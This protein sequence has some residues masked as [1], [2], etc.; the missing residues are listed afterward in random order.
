MEKVMPIEATEEDLKNAHKAL[1]QVAEL[2]VSLADSFEN[3]EESRYAYEA[4]AP[5]WNYF[6]KSD[7][8]LRLRNKAAE[9]MDKLGV[10]IDD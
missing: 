10:G 6:S 4:I 7:D 8:L 5:A 2:L 3:E 9:M 1:K